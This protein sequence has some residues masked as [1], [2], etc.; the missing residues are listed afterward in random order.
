VGQQSHHEGGDKQRQQTPAAIELDADDPEGPAS[1]SQGAVSEQHALPVSRHGPEHERDDQG[2]DDPGDT[3]P[4]EQPVQHFDRKA[5]TD[6]Q[7]ARIGEAI[8]NHRSEA[9]VDRVNLP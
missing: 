4:R 1:Y 5:E 3:E 8:A 9:L 2:R 6:G 7:K